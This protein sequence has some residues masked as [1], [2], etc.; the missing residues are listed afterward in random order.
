MQLRTRACI[1]SSS[2]FTSLRHHNH[3]HPFEIGFSSATAAI[4]YLAYKFTDGQATLPIEVDGRV[5]YALKALFEIIFDL[6][7][8]SIGHN[9]TMSKI[10]EGPPLPDDQ[11]ASVVLADRKCQVCVPFT[12]LIVSGG[13]C[14]V[15]MNYSV[16][17]EF[18]ELYDRVTTTC[19]GG[20]EVEEDFLAYREEQKA[21]IHEIQV[22]LC[23]LGVDFLRGPK[24]LF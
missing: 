18:N 8:F 20:G 6:S 11:Y 9:D 22:C 1:L 15:D 4:A 3:G 2:P 19:A 17:E 5:V 13:I 14:G 23:W 21:K 7:K 24:R 10:H 12:Q 16:R